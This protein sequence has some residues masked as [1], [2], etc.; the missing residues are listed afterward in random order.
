MFVKESDEP[1]KYNEQREADEDNE[2]EHDEL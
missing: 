1:L 2:E